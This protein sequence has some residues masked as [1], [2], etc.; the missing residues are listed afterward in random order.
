MIDTIVFLLNE[1]SFKLHLD[2]SF[3]LGTIWKKNP[4]KKDLLLGDYKPRLTLGSKYCPRGKPELNLKVELSLPKLIFNNNFEE[5]FYKDRFKVFK[6]LVEKLKKM[7]VTTTE[8]AIANAQV[9]SV[10]Y[11]KNIAFIDGTTPSYF[12][13]KIKEA[14]INRSL[15]VNQTDYC[16]YGHCYKWHCNAYEVVFYDKIK[17]LLKANVSSK[18][19]IEKDN[20]IQINF[21]KNFR[22]RKFEVLRMEVRL[23]KRQKI[24]QLF[25]KLNIKSDLIFKKLFKPAISKKVLLYYLDELEN[26]RPFLLD[27]KH[28][29]E[30]ELLADLI[31][32]NSSLGPKRILQIY[33]LKHAIDAINIGELRT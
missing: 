33:G 7:G 22:R 20:E 27:Y 13:N 23:N 30:K 31:F 28:K 24:K 19:A 4:T 1:N 5:L 12:I 26:K 9:T 3:P 8:E 25:K 10:H 17:D 29:S 2:L 15:D 21:L 11:S 6:K 14:N 18:R 16:N 32:N